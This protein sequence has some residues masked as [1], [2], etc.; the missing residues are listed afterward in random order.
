MKCFPKSYF[1]YLDLWLPGHSSWRMG[2]HLIWI[3]SF[4]TFQAHL[5]THGEASFLSIIFQQHFSLT[6]AV[7]WVD[8]ISS[9]H[10]FV[11]FC[12]SGFDYP[13][14]IFD[15]FP[16]VTFAW[17]LT[18][19]VVEMKRLAIMQIMVGH[20]IIV[21]ICPVLDSPICWETWWEVRWSSF[22]CD[23]PRWW[24]MQ[25]LGCGSLSLFWFGCVHLD[26]AVVALGWMQCDE[27]SESIKPNGQYVYPLFRRSWLRTMLERH[28]ATYAW[29]FIFLLSKWF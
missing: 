8:Y 10:R 19:F 13:S 4:T 21:D 14:P 25:N 16:L 17:A 2:L 15:R 20:C 1:T 23:D 22:F 29:F 11:A 5:M 3:G 6:Q 24:C 7:F 9:K 18:N 12:K 28:L 27:L 26:K